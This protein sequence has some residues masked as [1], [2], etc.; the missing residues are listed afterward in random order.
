M[1]D[2][3][4]IGICGG[5]FDPFHNGH[6]EPIRS[7]MPEIGWDRVVYMPAFR[8][9]FK[10]AQ[11]TVSSWHRFTMA[12]MATEDDAW[13][14]V[15]TW[16]LERERISYTVETLEALSDSYAGSRLDWIIGDDNLPAL[17]LWRDIGRI[18]ELANFVVPRRGS[19][20]L[21]E[22]L[23]QRVATPA[24]APRA[25][26]VIFVHNPAVPVSSTEIR[27]RLRS[28]QPIG[29]LV[30]PAVARHIEKYRLYDEVDS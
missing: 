18:L 29:D 10:S 21:P 3:E 30:A 26:G 20:P 25:G 12:V 13:S 16:E 23:Q 17:L 11:T 22:P 7:A 14:Q 5:T 27:M 4:R 28:R 9:P 15:S 24:D 1:S 19:A 8:Q 6:R 2:P